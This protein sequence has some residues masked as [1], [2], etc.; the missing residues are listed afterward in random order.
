MLTETHE[1]EGLM[2]VPRCRGRARAASGDYLSQ[3]RNRRD[4]ERAP[5]PRPCCHP[6]SAPRVRALALRRARGR[7]MSKKPYRY[8]GVPAKYA[9]APWNEPYKEYAKRLELHSFGTG[10]PNAPRDYLGEP[11]DYLAMPLQHPQGGLNAATN[12]RHAP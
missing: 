12:R 7:R 3:G 10:K 6:G 1:C 2:R 5:R 8:P 11:I 9:Y 4:S